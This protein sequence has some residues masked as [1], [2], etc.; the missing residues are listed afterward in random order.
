VDL[1]VG[2]RPNQVCKRLKLNDIVKVNEILA[3]QGLPVDKKLPQ[4]FQ[5][6][7]F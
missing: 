6:V 4:S 3:Q 1:I 5:N 2:Q 7:V